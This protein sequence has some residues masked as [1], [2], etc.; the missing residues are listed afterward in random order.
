M[1]CDNKDSD[2][3]K[4][5]KSPQK[6]DKLVEFSSSKSTVSSSQCDVIS[7]DDKSKNHELTKD[8]STTT[9]E[10]RSD[11]T[12]T[13]NSKVSSSTQITDTITSPIVEKHN[14]TTDLVEMG[15]IIEES[16]NKRKDECVVAEDEKLGGSTYTSSNLVQII[17]DLNEEHSRT[18][19]EQ[20]LE[21]T[22]ISKTLEYQE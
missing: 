3:N 18:K 9:N 4:N 5:R 17:K 11:N 16:Q 6:E 8:L 7:T 1:K 14:S 22:M 13:M 20:K 12:A 19:P 21:E 10:I 2:C 15:N